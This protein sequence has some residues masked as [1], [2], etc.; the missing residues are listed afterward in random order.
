[1]GLGLV[2]AGCGRLPLSLSLFKDF[3]ITEN[4][5]EERRRKEGLGREK[6]ITLEL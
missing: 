3:P 4:S 2:W 1:L 6:H 5:K